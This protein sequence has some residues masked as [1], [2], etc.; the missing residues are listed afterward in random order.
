M[1]LIGGGDIAKGEFYRQDDWK[2]V[3]LG[4]KM[5]ADGTLLLHDE[6][7]SN[8]GVKDECAGSGMLRARLTQTGM[9]GTWKGSLRDIE[10]TVQMRVETAHVVNSHREMRPSLKPGARRVAR[11]LSIF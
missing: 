5:Q 7:E 4:G 11:Q 2:P 1:H 8:C 9:N 10:G 6:Q 3:I